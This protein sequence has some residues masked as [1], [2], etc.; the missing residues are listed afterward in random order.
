MAH[1]ENVCAL[2]AELRS[3]FER[4]EE[5]DEAVRR[6]LGVTGPL[7]GVMATLAAGART[8]PQIARERRV[9]RQHVQALVTALAARKLCVALPNPAHARSPLIELTP[10][11]RAVCD[12]LIECEQSMMKDLSRV[13]TAD[14]GTALA[15]LRRVSAALAR[16]QA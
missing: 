15:V 13:L 6:Q 5:A 4:L 1:E 3:V 8:V 11:G 10:R 7:Q 2:V 12:T 16:R 9:S 14:V